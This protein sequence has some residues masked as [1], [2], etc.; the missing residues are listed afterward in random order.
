MACISASVV[1][2][3]TLFASYTFAVPIAPALSHEALDA[4]D[5]PDMV[6]H[7]RSYWLGVIDH[8]GVSPYN[9]D[10]SFAVY[11]NVMEYDHKYCDLLNAKY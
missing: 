1:L 7:H 3:M 8:N 2:C 10:T 4:G 5:L 11:R 6:F 9:N